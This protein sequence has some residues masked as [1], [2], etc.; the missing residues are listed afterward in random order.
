MN[1]GELIIKNQMIGLN[2][3]REA[4]MISV[5]N[6]GDRPI[7]IGSH[8]HF[9]ESNKYLQFNREEAFGCRLDIPAGTAVRFEPEEKKDVALIKMG[10]KQRIIGFNNLTEGQVNESAKQK[11]LL[12]AK[13]RGF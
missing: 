4:K 1:P 13:L 5:V 10:G 6:K 3:G 7:Q 8:F 2:S 11:A 12:N 9:F